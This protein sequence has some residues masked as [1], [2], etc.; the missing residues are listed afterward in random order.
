MRDRLNV[1]GFV[2]WL[3]ATEILGTI[4]VAW[5]IYAMEISW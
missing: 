1:T 4:L 5:L 2:L 3:L